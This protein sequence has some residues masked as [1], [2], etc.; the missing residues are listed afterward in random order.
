MPFLV[1]GWDLR[2]FDINVGLT[3]DDFRHGAA[4]LCARN[5]TAGAAEAGIVE[6]VQPVEGRFVTIVTLHVY[7]EPDR[8]I[9]IDKRLELCEVEVYAKGTSACISSYHHDGI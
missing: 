4:L 7:S 8:R 9:I 1:E 6:C 3:S 5:V 2:G